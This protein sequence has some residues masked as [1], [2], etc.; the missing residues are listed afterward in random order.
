[1]NILPWAQNRID[2]LTKSTIWKTLP[3]MRLMR[4]RRKEADYDEETKKL[5]E[6]KT[7]FIDTI[8]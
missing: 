2:W 7:N 3:I 4:G 6:S 8:V 1:M 5:I